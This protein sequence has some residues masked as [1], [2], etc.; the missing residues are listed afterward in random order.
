MKR[1]VYIPIL[2]FFALL[3]VALIVFGA[4]LMSS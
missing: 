2:A 3:G 4:V 1:K